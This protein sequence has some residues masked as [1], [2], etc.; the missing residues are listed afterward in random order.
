[1]LNNLTRC[2]STQ[3][4]QVDWQC[5]LRDGTHGKPE[6]KWR[7]YFSRPQ[8]SF[9]MMLENCAAANQEYQKSHITPQ[10][11]RPDRRSGAISIECIRDEPMNFRRNPGCEGTQV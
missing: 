8:Q 10:D 6:E 4:H 1:M 2:S 11:R 3:A 7:R 9:D 5:N